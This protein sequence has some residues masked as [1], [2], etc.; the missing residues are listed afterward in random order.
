[1][2]SIL[3]ESV[4]SVKITLKTITGQ[5]SRLDVNDTNTNQGCTMWSVFVHY[6]I[7]QEDIYCN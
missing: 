3:N 2:T 4:Y 7:L 5:I 6:I 1:M